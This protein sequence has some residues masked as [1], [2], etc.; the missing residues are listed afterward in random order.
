[1]ARKMKMTSASRPTHDAANIKYF[2]NLSIAVWSFGQP[3]FSARGDGFV[4]ARYSTHDLPGNGILRLVG[5]RVH[6]RSQRVP[7]VRVIRLRH[8]INRR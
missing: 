6:L 1:M 3:I 4:V 2:A 5:Q 8:Q 7:I